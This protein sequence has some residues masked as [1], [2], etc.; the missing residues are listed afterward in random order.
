MVGDDGEA[1]GTGVACCRP[2]K[3]ALAATGLGRHKKR[4]TQSY[5]DRSKPYHEVT[6]SFKRSKYCA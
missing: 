5:D 6:I 4:G 3:A 2:W 1:G